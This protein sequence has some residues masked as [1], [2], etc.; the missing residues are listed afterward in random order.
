MTGT[1]HFHQSARTWVAGPSKQNSTFMLCYA[2]DVYPHD[3]REGVLFFVWSTFDSMTLI[4]CKFEIIFAYDPNEVQSLLTL[5]A[6]RPELFPYIDHPQA[7]AW[8]FHV[9]HHH[10]W[11]MIIS[12]ITWSTWGAL[13]N[14]SHPHMNSMSHNFVKY[15]LS[16]VWICHWLMIFWRVDVWLQGLPGTGIESLLKWH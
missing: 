11:I 16:T 10:Q 14:L 3:H 8:L 15:V 13:V 4:S 2:D 7:V 1:L 12:C 6:P 5:Q 9:E